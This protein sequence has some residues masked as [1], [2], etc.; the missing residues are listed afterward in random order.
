MIHM[1]I[2]INVYKLFKKISNNFI[3]KMISYYKEKKINFWLLKNLNTRV[4]N[5]KFILNVV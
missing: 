5:N 1:K 4:L 2:F 3:L